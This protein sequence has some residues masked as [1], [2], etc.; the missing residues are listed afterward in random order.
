MEPTVSQCSNGYANRN[1]GMLKFIMNGGDS[2]A[3]EFQIFEIITEIRI[4][5]KSDK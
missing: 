2:R 3:E 4:N 1:D 5:I